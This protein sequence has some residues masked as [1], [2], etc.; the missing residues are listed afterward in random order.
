MVEVELCRL[1]AVKY[2]RPG[3]PAFL[4]LAI[5]LFSVLALQESESWITWIERIKQP[6]GRRTS[7]IA[8]ATLAVVAVPFFL[9]Y[10]FNSRTFSISDT[11]LRNQ[12][13][14]LAFLSSFPKCSQAFR[15]GGGLVRGGLLSSKRGII[16]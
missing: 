16:G 8:E 1:C 9:F 2:K 10:R 11:I 13:P 3:F 14:G 12:F 4:P 5:F 15:V 6:G 7:W